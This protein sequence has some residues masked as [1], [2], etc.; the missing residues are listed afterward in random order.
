MGI[1]TIE[2]TRNEDGSPGRTANPIRARH[3]VTGKV[4]WHCVMTSPGC[5]N[6]YAQTL[7]GRFGTK[8]PF[9]QRSQEEVELF[10]D[11]KPME[12]L[13]RVRK[14]SRVFLCDMTDLFQ[15]AV[16]DEW[17]D[18]LFEIMASMDQHTFQILTKR[19]RRL[20]EYS[21][22]SRFAYK[23]P[24]NLWIGVSVE[25]QKYADERIPDLLRVPAAVR[26]LSVE[27]M[28]EPI[29]LARWSEEGL[30]C[31][32]CSW[33]GSEGGDLEQ[34]VFEGSDP[35]DLEYVCPECQAPCAHTP[36]DE[37][38]GSRIGWVICGGESGP[39]ARPFDLAW[40]RSLRDQCEAAGAP[41]FLKQCGSSP[42]D[43]DAALTVPG[44]QIKMSYE[45]AIEPENLDLLGQT[46]DAMRV[47]FRDKK[48]GSMEEWPEDIRVRQ[49]PDSKI[50]EAV[51]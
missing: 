4:G 40:A 29:N 39:H 50:L 34:K 26:F 11:L 12:A 23:F 22:L 41:Y 8:L 30:E 28:L 24:I 18:Q 44:A 36:L 7:N 13:R 49:F 6:C 2:W 35:E 1:T 20:L 16:P 48:G 45:Q 46:L 17:I 38:L 42:F 5:A 14:P 47:H 10:L 21:K 3:K 19:S 33:T 32:E 37:L 9:T 51:R 15:E 25:N 31:S 43:S 27:P